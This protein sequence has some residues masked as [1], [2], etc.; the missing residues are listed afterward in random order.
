MR[1]FL[2]TLVR[3][4]AVEDKPKVRDTEVITADSLFF[5]STTESDFN[6]VLTAGNGEGCHGHMDLLSGWIHG[7][8]R[9]MEVVTPKVRPMPS[10]T[11]TRRVCAGVLT[12]ACG[13]GRQPEGWRG[14]S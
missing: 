13:G 5:S 4:A 2:V 11:V 3:S 8:L 1:E 10:R 9:L 12:T 6:A 14:Y 7:G